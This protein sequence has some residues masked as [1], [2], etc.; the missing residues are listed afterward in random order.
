MNSLLHLIED[1]SIRSLIL[2]KMCNKYKRKG[3]NRL[4]LA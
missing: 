1:L 3:L 2:R 4:E